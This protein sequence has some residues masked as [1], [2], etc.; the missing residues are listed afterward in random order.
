M[1]ARARGVCLCVSVCVSRFNFTISS[2]TASGSSVSGA[3]FSTSLPS[4]IGFGG[5]YLTDPVSGVLYLICVPTSQT[6]QPLGCVSYTTLCNGCITSIT[7]PSNI[8]YRTTMPPCTGGQGFVGGGQLNVTFASFSKPW[9]MY[10]TGVPMG[11][12]A[13][14][15]PFGAPNNIESL[16]SQAMLTVSGAT[17]MSSGGGGSSGYSFAVCL[18]IEFFYNYMLFLC[19]IQHRDVLVVVNK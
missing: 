12:N 19:K 4:T 14:G 9:S 17:T 10:V 13:T 5:L 1:F 8:C 6:T 18:Q 15:G 2:N 7:A 3:T 11:Y 16:A